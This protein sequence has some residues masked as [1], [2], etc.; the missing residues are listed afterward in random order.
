[1][2][3][4][5][6]AAVGFAKIISQFFVDVRQCFEQDAGVI[7]EPHLD[8]VANSRA[9]ATHLISLPQRR[10]LRGDCLLAFLSR[11]LSK[12]QTI[13]LLQFLGNALSLEEYRPPRD[14]CGM[15]RENDSDFHLSQ[16]LQNL[17]LGDACRPHPAQS[18]EE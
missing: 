18:P 7:V 15:G 14:L 17:L 2:A 8:L 16:P 13:Q 4:S 12:R 3:P 1:M 11:P 9:M 10:N 6:L 5:E